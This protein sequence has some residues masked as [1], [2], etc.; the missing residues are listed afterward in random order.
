MLRDVFYYGQKPNAHP[1]EKFAQD[2]N[3]ARR[4]ATTE[5][6]WII[7]EFCDYTRFDWD[8]DFEFLHDNDVWAESH[9]N[10]WPSKYQ[11]DSGTW[12]CAKENS[13]IIIYR[14]DVDIVPRKPVTHTYWQILSP[15][16]ESKFD[17]GW[18][19]DPIF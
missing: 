13:A 10:V 19:P 3:D 7:N 17:F 8:F 16:D 12:L 6:F 14:N 15:I 9:N 1:R 5:H 18:H 11:K 2:I 4:Q